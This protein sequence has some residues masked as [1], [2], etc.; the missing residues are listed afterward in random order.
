M[1]TYVC[2]MKYTD[3]GIKDIKNAP[4]R[5]EQVQKA[6]AA[7]GGKTLGSYLLMGEYDRIV[8][9]EAPSEEAAMTFLLGLGAQGNV[10]T[11]T[12]RAFTDEEFVEMIKKL[13]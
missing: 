3:Q 10:R 6:A 2:L 9:S 7:A 11:T 4:A 1:P 5:I 12:F 13:P 8:I